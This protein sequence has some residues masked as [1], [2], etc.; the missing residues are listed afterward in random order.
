M[1][2]RQ[3]T[4]IPLLILLLAAGA[5]QAE[6]HPY[7]D[8]AARDD[9]YYDQQPTAADCDIIAKRAS[10]DAGGLGDGRVA[11]GGARGAIVGGILGGRKGAKRGAALGAIA[12][13][14]RRAAARNNSYE[15]VF[16]DCM[17][18]RSRY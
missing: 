16:D 8:R 6:H 15:R 11:R 17:R 10:R 12:G 1:R 7:N 13:G 5:T 14:A 18:G 9:R 2:R 4:A 3:G